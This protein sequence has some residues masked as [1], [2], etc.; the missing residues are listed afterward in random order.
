MFSLISIHRSGCE[1]AAREFGQCY[2]TLD[3]FP[4]AIAQYL[5]NDAHTSDSG[6]VFLLTADE[7]QWMISYITSTG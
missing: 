6:D 2:Y 1:R 4:A 5:E 7:F 3:A